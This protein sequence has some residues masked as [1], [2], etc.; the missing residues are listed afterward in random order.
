[1][2]SGCLD[3]SDPGALVPPTA[4]QDPAL[5]QIEIS[6]AGHRRTVHLEA[7]GDPDAP[8][9]LALHG[10]G[11]DFRALKAPLVDLTDEYRVVLWDQRGSGLSERVSRDEIT[12]GAAVEEIDAVADRFSPSSPVTLIG[13]SFGAAYSA[14]YLGR[15]PGR[16][17]QAVL[18]EPL[19]LTGQI[20]NR[21]SDALWELDLA[22]EVFH[23]LTW[24]NRFLSA[25]DHERM[26]YRYRMLL[27]STALDF[28]CNP[29]DLPAWPV[30]RSGAFVEYVRGERLEGRNHDFTAGLGEFP[31]EV[32]ILGSE[33]SA[34]G[35]DFQVRY[36]RDLFREARVVEIRDAG[37]RMWTEQPDAMLAAVR[38]YL[39]QYR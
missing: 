17:R 37:H 13:H 5:P 8:V 14:L 25:A 26:D 28:Y 24:I 19:A 33:C 32:L 1:L 4:D 9:I 10:A 39:E 7:H 15:R 36:H 6:V 31:R 29:D 22:E 16:V 35:H 11:H 34:L 21:V 30:W 3:P 27:R 2:L 12:W 20:L 23:D 38:A 18:V